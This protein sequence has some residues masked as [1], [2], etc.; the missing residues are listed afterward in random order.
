MARNSKFEK[1]H[2]IIQN[3]VVKCIKI[4][5][6]LNKTYILTKSFVLLHHFT[7]K[8]V[9]RNLK[10]QGRNELSR[11]GDREGK[12]LPTHRVQQNLNNVRSQKPDGGAS[13]RCPP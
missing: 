5:K 2:L 1:Y 3:W 6:K 7:T 9:A 10:S 12:L 13:D 4:T 11:G 8:L